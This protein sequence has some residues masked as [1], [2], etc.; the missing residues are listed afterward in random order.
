MSE[1]NKTDEGRR[2]FLK[3]ATAA[4]PAAAAVV[5]SGQAAEA[6]VEDTVKSGLSDTAHTRAYYA[7]ARF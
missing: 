2:S 3:L 7:S 6:S 4:A 5:A 1:Q